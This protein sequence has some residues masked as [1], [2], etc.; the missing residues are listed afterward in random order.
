MKTG[1]AKWGSRNVKEY[2]IHYSHPR[3]R[4]WNSQTVYALIQK[5]KEE[6]ELIEWISVFHQSFFESPHYII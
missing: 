5:E 3:K 1:K 4:K 6:K 2:E